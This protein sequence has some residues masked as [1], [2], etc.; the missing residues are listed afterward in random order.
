M[1]FK[2]DVKKIL[3]LAGAL[4]LI[5]VNVDAAM[6]RFDLGNEHNNRG[7]KRSLSSLS[8]SHGILH[9]WQKQGWIEWEIRI[10][11]AGEYRIV[12]DY[13]AA[14]EAGGELL[15]SI[16]DSPAL[17]VELPPTGGWEKFKQKLSEK[18]VYLSAGKH[19]L[20]L[21]PLACKGDNL[22]IN[23]RGLKLTQ[24]A[25]LVDLSFIK[26]P[27]APLDA[28]AVSS[29]WVEAMITARGLNIEDVAEFAE[30][31]WRAYPLQC[32]WF[33][34]DNTSHD[35]PGADYGFDFRNDFTRFLAAKNTEGMQ[36]LLKKVARDLRVEV[37][38]PEDPKAILMGY[39]ELCQK[40]RL[41]RLVPL[42]AKCNQ[43]VYA[44]HH[45]LGTIY[46]ATELQWCC[47]RQEAQSCVPGSELRLIT[48]PSAS[49]PF[50]KDELLFDAKSG[51]VR[52]PE[53]SF[54][55]ERL[56]FAWRKTYSESYKIFEMK[57][58]TGEIRP[59]T[60]PDSYG[61]DFEPC[62]LPNGDIIFSSQ[63]C[64]QPVTCG[65]G[66]SFNLY[67]MNQD[68]KYA[69]RLGFDQTQTAFP[70]LLDDGRV[71]YTRRDYNDR[72][73]TY[74]HALFVMNSD[75]TSQT[76][77]YGNQTS[78]PTSFQ[79]TR[80]I[81]GTGTTLS[82]AGGYHTSQGGKLVIIDPRKGMQD[83]Q[84]L[85][86]INWDHTKKISWGDFFGRE[87]DQYAYPY[88][89]DAES[90]LISY[91]P[92]GGYLFNKTGLGIG[93]ESVMCYKTYFMTMD[94]TR[95]VLAADSRISCTQAVPVMPRSV[96]RQRASTVDYTKRDGLLYVQ[97]VYFGPGAKGVTR[98][99]IKKIR[100][101]RLFYKAATVGG[102]NWRPPRNEVGPGKKYSGIGILSVTPAGV[103]TASFETKEILGEVEVHADGSAM[104]EVP[105][106]APLYLQL[107]DA[108]GDT[109]Q[110]MRSWATLMPNE[111]FS[112]VGCHEDKNS[113][114]LTTGHVTEAMKKAPQKLQPFYD[115]S[116][117]PFSYAKSIQP[118]WNR[119]CVSC[120]APGKE[121]AKIDLTDTIVIDDPTET[122]CNSTRRRFYQSYLTLLQVKPCKED[123]KKLDPGRPN[124]WVDYYTRLLTVEPIPP[125]YAGAAKSGLLQMLRKGHQ[126]VQLSTEELNKISA[127]IDLNV[128]FIGEY[129]E[130][131]NWDA[132]ALKN[133][134]SRI[135]H[136]Q[137][138]ENRDA[139]NI[140]QYIAE[141]Q[142]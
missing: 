135:Q 34:Q 101:N 28:P 84:G 90:F 108:N 125:Y 111:K 98:G 136:R 67:I 31:M 91:E 102:A 39:V 127:W 27:A 99:I 1:T 53:L 6:V 79:H 17:Q 128:P 115:L 58:K 96:P 100:V 116:G 46:L 87:G 62:Y 88:P 109:V 19:K 104:F 3:V 54:D 80:A 86:F 35:G 72:G 141:G 5:I 51:I 18:T 26:P 81:P 64:V 15:V 121:A 103:G 93:S 129:D 16:N 55:G 95:E 89:L 69:R 57:V 76:E 63:R 73:Q 11:D 25:E 107:I 68:G 4:A 92:I 12:L 43:I 71:V 41:Q 112:C 56:L 47:P 9:N 105:A 10:M 66:E 137:N 7:G 97:D 113:P 120:H 20:K 13:S 142:P 40:R 133:Y 75:G 44:K 65:G 126:K 45:N 124:E 24:R 48:L 52:D 132:V 8:Y 22:F 70:H 114:P 42:Q 118:I 77:Y 29:A 119:H 61:A 78:E 38:C 83:Y 50:T 134:A 131:N 37:E 85:T 36:Q 117:K 60:T 139:E 130:M 14:S 59:L 123:S 49:S 106:R 138:E 140:R 21:T 110:T 2:K 30:K 33:F 23:L 122:G 82:I 94:G 32:D 74:S